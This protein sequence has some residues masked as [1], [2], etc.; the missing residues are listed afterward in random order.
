MAW[1]TRGAKPASSGRGQ[2]N[3]L[4]LDLNAGRVRAAAG[5][6]GKLRNLPLDDPH[7]ELPMALSLE[8]VRQPAVGRAGLALCR[9]M[10]HL[11]CL[12]FLPCLGTD[13][14]WRAGRHRIDAGRALGLV[15]EELRKRCDKCDAVG[16]ILPAYLSVPQ[17]AAVIGVMGRA[18]VQPR[19]TAVVP[20]ALAADLGDPAGHTQGERLRVVAGEL[21][22]GRRPLSL[23]SVAL[24][25]DAD[26]YALTGAAVGFEDGQ[27]R[28]MGTAVSP[29][30]GLRFWRERLLDALADRCIRLCRRD[31]R[32]SAATEQSLYEQIDDAL[33]RAR[34]GQKIDLTVRS[35]HWFQNLVQGSDDFDGYCA[36]LVRQTVAGLSALL[37]D[38]AADPP[39]A[40]WVTHA[41]ARLPG[42]LNAVHQLA[43]ERTRLVALQPDAVARAGV[44]LTDRWATGELPR[45]HLDT[46]IALPRAEKPAD[47]ARAVGRGYD[48]PAT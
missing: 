48:A 9:K 27:A 34:H 16:L 7:E 47:P 41:A 17:V 29:R 14:E 35:A 24:V 15:F 30:L 25:V 18:W 40:V 36:P 19:G 2:A 32:D 20:L 11:A 39:D 43:S 23:G 3:L 21:P 26:D 37:R 8:P 38:A 1:L 10:P 45:V 42:L 6:A 12:E 28:L 22:A 5:G 46:S 33:D 44:G 4:A 31:P 13:R